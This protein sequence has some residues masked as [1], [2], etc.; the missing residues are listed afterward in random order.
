MQTVWHVLEFGWAVLGNWRGLVAAAVSIVASIPNTLLPAK[1]KAYLE[2]RFPLERRRKALVVV[3]FGLVFVSCFLAWDDQ[4]SQKEIAEKKITELTEGGRYINKID[5]SIL[6]ENISKFKDIFLGPFVPLCWTQNDKE[7]ERFRNQI[8]DAFSRAGL[9]T[10]SCGATPD[11]ID[12]VGVSIRNDDGALSEENI[13]KIINIFGSA[14][15]LIQEKRPH[16]DRPW[17]E[18]KGIRFYIYIAPNPI[19]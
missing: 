14:N 6:S 7:A 17:K 3:A 8:A 16:N 13:K 4:R 10:Q 1:A 12:D 19:K 9:Q 5:M 15:I 18:K 11:G 2:A